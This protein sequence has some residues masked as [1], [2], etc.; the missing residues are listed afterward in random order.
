M[1][2][3]CCPRFPSRLS[4]MLLAIAILPF[5]GCGVID[6]TPQPNVDATVDARVRATVA[7][8]SQSAIVETTTPEF[9]DTGTAAP[10]Q[11]RAPESAR[12]VQ[13]EPT[14]AAGSGTTPESQ[15]GPTPAPATGPEPTPTPQPQPT[16]E[17]ESEPTSVPA[18]APGP[19]QEPEAEPAP[20]PLAGPESTPQPTLTPA[21]SPEPTA[22]PVPTP[23]PVSE[24]DLQVSLEADTT[25]I[26][27]DADLVT[28]FTVQNLGPGD[29]DDVFL[30]FS[31][32]ALFVP[33]L[34][35]PE[36]ICSGLQCNVGYLGVNQSLS[37]ELVVRAEVFL[38]KDV[39]ST[40]R[41][42]ARV[43]GNRVDL[44]TS[45]NDSWIDFAYANGVPGSLLWSTRFPDR[46]LTKSG[47]FVIGDALYFGA[48]REIFAVSMETGEFLWNVELGG[49]ARALGLHDGA[50]IATDGNTYSLDQST[51]D[52]NWKFDAV[53]EPEGTWWTRLVEGTVYVKPLNRPELYSI[54][55]SSGSLNWKYALPLE[56]GR[57][58]DPVVVEGDSVIVKQNYE[59]ISLTTDHGEVNWV[60]DAKD[61]PNFH[62]RPMVHRGLLYFFTRRDIYGIDLDTGEMLLHRSVESL[63]EYIEAADAKTRLAGGLFANGNVYLAITNLDVLAL[64]EGMETVLWHY[65][66]DDPPTSGVMPTYVR[67]A[68][69]DMIY[70]LQPFNFTREQEVFEHID[71][72]YA[73]DDESGRPLWHF[74]SL[75]GALDITFHKDVIYAPSRENHPW[76]SYSGRIEVIHALTGEIIRRIEFSPEEYQLTTWPSVIISDGVLYGSAGNRVFALTVER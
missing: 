5:L 10:T 2:K 34:L 31:H 71:G 1:N 45:N 24:P 64:D 73:L 68:A 8:D 56:E 28:R 41:V 44:D 27:P 33:V 39:E 53:P 18:N 59:V 25:L 30:E 75:G 43:H 58:I 21:A 55:A 46:F 52:L 61:F 23:E 7:A 22:T 49:R 62:I 12:E 32:S 42:A 6:V 36:A 16:E 3:L 17:P 51:G 11:E 60:F 69:N 9:S 35:T 40:S 70:L 72:I 50:L 26:T 67:H 4:L 14:P 57:R 65:S 20:T 76:S 63:F 66:H 48:G 38:D 19:T 47:L 29:V 37:G 54:D 13:P 74:D 15:S